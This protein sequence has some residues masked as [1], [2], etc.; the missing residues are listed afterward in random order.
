LKR[1]NLPKRKPGLFFVGEPEFPILVHFIFSNIGTAFLNRAVI[2]SAENRDLARPASSKLEF[3]SS[4]LNSK[5]YGVRTSNT[6]K[7]AKSA[8]LDIDGWVIKKLL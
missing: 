4:F 2:H 8:T 6:P 1:I 7:T 5:N 3:N